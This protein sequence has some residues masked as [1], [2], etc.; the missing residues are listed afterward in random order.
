MKEVPVLHLVAL[1][2]FTLGI[3]MNNDT[4]KELISWFGKE[5]FIRFITE[6]CAIT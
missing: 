1:G 4:I 5:T 3:L 6:E 2:C